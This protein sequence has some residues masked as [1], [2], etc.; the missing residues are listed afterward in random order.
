[1]AI[2][3]ESGGPCEIAVVTEM[4]Y[5]E[6]HPGYEPPDEMPERKS[7]TLSK[8]VLQVNPTA[9]VIGSYRLVAYPFEEFEEDVR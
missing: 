9:F 7:R 6:L 4:S 8:R 5:A 2:R 3:I 1:M